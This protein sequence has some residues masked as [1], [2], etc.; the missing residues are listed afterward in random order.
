MDKE[1]GDEFLFGSDLD[2]SLYDNLKRP[3]DPFAGGITPGDVVVEKF[4]QIADL[5]CL[6]TSFVTGRNIR[7]LV[8]GNRLYGFEK[9]K[10]Q[11][12]GV[13]TGIHLYEMM[14]GEWR[15]NREFNS[16]IINQVLCFDW[17]KAEFQKFLASESESD[18]WMTRDS[19]TMDLQSLKVQWTVKKLD[20][21]E[22]YTE[23]IEKGVKSLCPSAAVVIPSVDRAKNLG[24]IDVMPL[25]RFDPDS[26]DCEPVT[27][28]VIALEYWRRRLG[29]EKNQVAYA[30][31]SGNDYTA[32]IHGYKGIVLENASPAVKER[33]MQGA[34]ER[35]T[36][37][38]LFF[39]EGNWGAFKDGTCLRGIIRG[40]VHHELISPDVV[41][42]NDQIVAKL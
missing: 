8:E 24:F 16:E 15:F 12:A 42:R 37:K 10:V 4:H 18:V 21:L 32:L 5:P 17:N 33:V 34:Q 26:A 29:Y 25:Y 27:G 38:S 13:D 39:P 41:F 1:R 28:K 19:E 2:G 35:G 20:D 3:A 23:I 40:L 22:R 11:F 31:D 6:V 14:N 9:C 36:L 7:E 30:G